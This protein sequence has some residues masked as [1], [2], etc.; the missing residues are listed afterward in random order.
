MHMREGIL[1]LFLLGYDGPVG[2][3][4]GVQI[5]IA[6]LLQL[7]CWTCEACRSG[8]I[9]AM[10]FRSQHVRLSTASDLHAAAEGAGRGGQG[11][12]WMLQA[13]ARL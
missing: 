9:G 4:D 7:Q 11:Q 1:L 6:G 12:A 3:G 5:C 8:Q 13:H 10:C 2:T